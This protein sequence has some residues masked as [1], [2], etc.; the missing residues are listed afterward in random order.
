[1]RVCRRWVSR[2]L[3]V[4]VLGSAPACVAPAFNSSQYQSK[5]AKTADEAASALET[6]RLATSSAVRH[7]LY[8]PP[9]DVS[10]SDAEDIIGTVSGTFAS[11][12]PPNDQA[13]VLRTELLALL[14]KAGS[15][16]ERARVAFRRGA[17]ADAASALYGALPIVD[18]L[19]AIADRY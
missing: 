8:D 2:I 7:G 17:K 4:L 1:M 12:Q 18:R 15:V 9:I 16:V 11:V 14:E 13:D 10:L 3:I 19:R 5:V 6:A